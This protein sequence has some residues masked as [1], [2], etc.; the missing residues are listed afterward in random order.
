[1]SQIIRQVSSNI[2]SDAQSIVLGGN[3]T[4]I[5]GIVSFLDSDLEEEDFVLPVVEGTNQ[6]SENGPPCSIDDYLRANNICQD[7]FGLPLLDI[8][9]KLLI[10]GEI[11]VN[12]FSIQTVAYKVQSLVRGPSGVRLVIKVYKYVFL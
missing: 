2:G 8:L 3:L 6:T 12:D 1:M 9:T 4:Q 10:S 7:S 11:D 5:P